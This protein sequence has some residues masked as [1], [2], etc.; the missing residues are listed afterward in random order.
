MG[1]FSL[2]FRD[3]AAEHKGLSLDPQNSHEHQ[4]LSVVPALEGTTRS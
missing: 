3:L 4:S 1:G 2:A